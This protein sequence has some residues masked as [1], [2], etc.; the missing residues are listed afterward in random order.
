MGKVYTETITLL[1]AVKTH[2][3]LIKSRSNADNG[4]QM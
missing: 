1:I 3:C 4:V 2:F